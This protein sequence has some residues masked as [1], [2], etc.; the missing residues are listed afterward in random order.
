MATLD[1]LVWSDLGLV[2]RPRTCYW[3]AQVEVRNR[4][5][6]PQVPL[7][8]LLWELHDN[9]QHA[10][11]ELTPGNPYALRQFRLLQSSMPLDVPVAPA[12]TRALL[13]VFDCPPA[14]GPC[15]LHVREVG[16]EAG[17]R[18]TLRPASGSA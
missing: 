18:W 5:V 11:R 16:S 3:T 4:T 1:Q 15:H 17:A 9:A 10:Y 12:E 2:L 14:P 8:T 13:L 7:Q 6:E